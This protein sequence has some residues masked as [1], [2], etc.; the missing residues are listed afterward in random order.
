[1]EGLAVLLI[2]LVIGALVSGPIALVIAIVALQKANRMEE[3]RIFRPAAPPRPFVPPAEWEKTSPPAAPEKPQT[4]ATE[5]AP[6]EPVYSPRPA[7]STYSAPLPPKVPP[8][9]FIQS[10]KA[11]AAPPSDLLSLEQQFGTRWLPVA[12]II[13]VIAAALFFLKYAYDN[14]WLGPWM[15]VGI[16]AAGGLIALVVGELTRRRGYE[17]VARGMTALGFALL[18]AAAFA[19]YRV[20]DLVG[21][22]PA[23]A[24]AV[25]ITLAAMT[26]AAVLNEVLIAFLSLLGGYL[27]PIMVSTGENLPV[28]LFSYVLVLSLGAMVIAYLR[29]W[30][31][32]NVAAFIGTYAIYTGWFFEFCE[33][34]LGESA[35]PALKP[36]A[37]FWLAVFF[38]VFLFMP[39]LYGLLRRVAARP[40]EI[41]LVL[42]AGIVTV[43]FLLLMMYEDEK[44]QLALWTAAVGVVY[45]A[46]KELARR[47]CPEDENLQI[48]LTVIGIG[49]LTAAA[50][51]YWT[52]QPLIIAWAVEGAILTVIGI[53]C[54]NLWIKALSVLVFILSING[55]FYWVTPLHDGPFTPVRTAAFGTWMFVAAAI[56]A[57]HFAWRFSK[58][59]PDTERL[60]MADLFYTAALLIAAFA[61][62]SEAVLHC[63]FNVIESARALCLHES[64]LIIAAVL[65]ALLLVRPLCPPANLS[66]VAGIFALMGASVF[67]FLSL[68]EVYRKPFL[69]FLNLPFLT[70]LL[71]PLACL[72]AGRRLEHQEGLTEEQKKTLTGLA[73]ILA[74]ALLWGLLTQEVYLYWYI[75]HRFAGPVVNWGF[76][77]NLS[78]SILWAVYGALLIVIGFLRRKRTLRY[79]ALA[80]F[81]LL[82]VKIFLF[83]TVSLKTGYRIAAFLVAGLILLTVSYLYQF[84]KKR[85]VFDTLLGPSQEEESRI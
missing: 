48:I 6:P 50:G 42:G 13:L 57:A 25:L 79:G 81:V 47:R 66:T 45:L 70:T 85:G 34:V 65:I 8:A 39:L 73:G 84:A 80:L 58:T 67:A 36:M 1:M 51:F 19:A 2:V 4:P 9:D 28:P 54:R 33:P 68:G 27:T 63:R 29:R 22:V 77:A 12:G 69:L 18:Y 15:R 41:G 75:R 74:A 46:V 59:L 38:I 56:L 26:Y 53:R 76:R 3:G 71:V 21:S 64:I 72:P 49:F 83:D 37:L 44:P 60:W 62:L 11:Q 10:R 40:E 30:R 61:C 24:A 16:V 52:R 14:N 5:T 23:F 20:Y 78:I 35:W 43:V 82:L 32:V 7:A 17:L 55:L 31:S